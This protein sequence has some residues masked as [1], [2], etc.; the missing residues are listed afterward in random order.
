MKWFLTAVAGAVIGF[1]GAAILFY[2]PSVGTVELG[3]L[4]EPYY[5]VLWENDEIR[6]VEHRLEPGARE[7]MHFHPRMIGYFLETS[8]VR[9]TES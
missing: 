3:E 5:N 8:T 2:S 4:P 6:L 9:I 7:P 1:L